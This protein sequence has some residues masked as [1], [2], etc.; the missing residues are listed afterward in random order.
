MGLN[1]AFKGLRHTTAVP[2]SHYASI[3]KVFLRSGTFIRIAFALFAF[4]LH[5]HDHLIP[6]TV[7]KN[8]YFICLVELPNTKRVFAHRLWTLGSRAF[9][10][11]LEMFSTWQRQTYPNYSVD[12]CRKLHTRVRQKG[13]FFQAL[14]T[15]M[16]STVV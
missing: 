15:T 4:L 8:N 12:R 5:G 2:A 6:I 7:A 16:S 3:F 14:M 11:N 13:R 1:S 9:E 10:I